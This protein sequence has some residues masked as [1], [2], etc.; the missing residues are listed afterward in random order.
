MF[1]TDKIK[2]IEAIED[3]CKIEK[4]WQRCAIV[5]LGLNVTIKP[6]LT[7]NLDTAV[8]HLARMTCS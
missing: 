8:E 5:V 6:N 3:I 1:K 7:R 4:N 2:N